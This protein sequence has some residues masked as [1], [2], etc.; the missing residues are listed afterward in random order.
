M[1]TFYFNASRNMVSADSM[2]ITTGHGSDITGVYP[3]SQPGAGLTCGSVPQHVLSDLH[4]WLH[5]LDCLVEIWG[6]KHT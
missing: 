6:C 3:S 5:H 1:P 2:R 4:N